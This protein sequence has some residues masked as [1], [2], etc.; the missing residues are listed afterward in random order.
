M[1]RITSTIVLLL[2]VT[3]INAQYSLVYNGGF[4]VIEKKIKEG[5]QIELT[6]EWYS[7]TANKADLFNRDAKEEAYGVPYNMHGEAEP[8]NGDGYAG[9]VVYSDKEAEP[10]QYLQTKLRESLEKGKIY[11]V[12][13]N[14]RLSELSKYASNNIAAYVTS[15][16]I[17]SKEIEEY[18]IEPQIIHSQNKVFEEQFDWVSICKT[19]KAEGGERY[20]TIGN[21]APQ[22]NIQ[23][24]KVKKPRSASGSQTRSSYY[25]ID[26]VSVY[27]MAGIEECDCEQ[28][29][30]GNSL[31][32]KYT[33]NVSTE[34]EVDPS[35]EIEFTKIYFE[36]L[37]SELNEASRID[38]AK[39]ASVLKDNPDIVIELLG[40]TDPLEEM[41]TTADISLNR[42]IKVK[43]ELIAAGVDARQIKMKN[44]EDKDPATDDATSAG[45]AKNR[46]VSFKVLEEF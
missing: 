8:L 34:M 41:K 29:E 17:S 24:E 31:Q 32:V 14:V 30:G 46:R 35:E 40:H 33:K 21:F 45:Q 13:F 10:R 3:S 4:D 42:A 6:T 20:L 15:K 9:I 43:D 38:I 37:E 16:K 7:P 22:D 39:V 36:H 25:Y 2:L 27:N 11:C 18:T 5:A 23:T 26:D 12:K 19:F 28:D 1:I 44:M